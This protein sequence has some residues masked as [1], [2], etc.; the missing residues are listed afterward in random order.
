[1]IYFVFGTGIGFSIDWGFIVTVFAFIFTWGLNHTG[2]GF[3][4]DWGFIV[5]VF[6]F[7]YTWGLNHTD[8]GFT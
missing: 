5:T 3:K 7:I 8:V 1:M 4:L 6:G 2:I